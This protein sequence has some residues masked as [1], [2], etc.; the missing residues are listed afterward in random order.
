MTFLQRADEFWK[1]FAEQEETLSDMATHPGQYDPDQVTSFVSEGIARLAM[2]IPFNMG[3]R[4]E[5]SFAVEGQEHL[6][7]LLPYLIRRK[8]QGLRHDWQFSPCLQ[9]SRGESF[10]FGMY[11]I[12]VSTNAIR[13]ST[14]YDP[15]NN[16]FSLRFYHP[17]LCGLPEEQ[18][19]N[20]FYILLE[21]TIGEGLS[22]VYVGD[23]QRADGPEEGMFPL[24]EL[25]ARIEEALDAMGHSRIVSPEERYTTYQLKPQAGGGLRRDVIAGVT[26]YIG[27]LNDYYA[28]EARAAGALAACGAKACF[29]FFP[30]PGE[31]RGDVLQ[32]RYDLEER[33]QDEVLG[34]RGSGRESGIVLGGALGVDHAYIDLLL[35]DEPAF[36]QRVRPLLAA[37]PY[38]FS[39]ADFDPA[40]EVVALHPTDRR[41]S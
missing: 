28:G 1:W 16:T 30:Y 26:C 29:L 24:T 13:V 19:F 40:G 17:D 3:G 8:P 15:D 34:P 31:D 39:L 2:D 33:L 41:L 12:R 4:H 27:L 14:G 22:Y 37:L 36:L 35:Y 32:A 5:F 11:G 7:Y 18:C 9:S 6:F 10:D 23:V 25:E 21:L 38:D 20:A